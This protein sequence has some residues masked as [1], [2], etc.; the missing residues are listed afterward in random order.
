[1]PK[2]S[3]SIIRT[4]QDQFL[5]V[6]VNFDGENYKLTI[7]DRIKRGKPL[8]ENL[9]LSNA[10]INSVEDNGYDKIS[11]VKKAVERKLKTESEITNLD[12]SLNANLFNH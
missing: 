9:A 11:A 2:K 12:G 10:F 6:L 1:M 7:N 5:N 4:N 8:C 3:T